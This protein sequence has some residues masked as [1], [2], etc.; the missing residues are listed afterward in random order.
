[1]SVRVNDSLGARELFTLL[2]VIGDHKAKSKPVD[3]F[4]LADRRNA[5]IDRNDKLTPSAAILSIAP[6]FSP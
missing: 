2:V 5:V 4:R 1:M 3:M 6:L